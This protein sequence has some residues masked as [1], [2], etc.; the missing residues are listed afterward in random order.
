M[1]IREFLQMLQ[2]VS[3]PNASGEYMARCPCHDDKT[4]SL[5]VTTKP[6]R[7]DGKERIYFHCQAGCTN[8]QIMTALGVKA[9][10]LIV[11]PNEAGTPRKQRESAAP[12]GVK[13]YQAKPIPPA[14]EKREKPPIDFAHP[15]KVYSYQELIYKDGGK[16]AHSDYSN[17]AEQAQLYSSGFVTSFFGKGLFGAYVTAKETIDD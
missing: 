15:D 10:D 4:A 17:Y 8:E 9:K 1:D 3:G 12:E 7:K 16:T 14:G 11:T 6:S 5:S 13:V 2:H